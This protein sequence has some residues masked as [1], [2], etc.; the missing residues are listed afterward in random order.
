MPIGVKAACT[1]PNSRPAFGF[2]LC[3]YIRTSGASQIIPIKIIQI[4]C[5][6]I[7]LACLETVTIQVSTVSHGTLTRIEN[8]L[9]PQM[10][11][12]PQAEY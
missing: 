5:S 3:I 12:K 6:N 7:M 8:P 10:S 2:S 11:D 9:A 4:S 1:E